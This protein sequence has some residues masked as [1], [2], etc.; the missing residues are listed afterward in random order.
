MPKSKLTRRRFDAVFA[1]WEK[2]IKAPEIAVSSNPKSYTDIK[3]YK[4]IIK[5]GKDALPFVMDKIK[6]GVFF[7]NEAALKLS[8][9]KMGDLVAAEKKI[10]LKKRM[11]VLTTR[12]KVF[13]SEQ[14]E[15]KLILKHIKM[16][17]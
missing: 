2:A 15:S 12:K 13:L 8:R 16:P 3:E 17:E 6:G 7:M 14:D 10:P 11:K 1:K 4:D 9:K 5:L